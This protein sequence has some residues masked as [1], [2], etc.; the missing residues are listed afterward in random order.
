V[1]RGCGIERLG[2]GRLGIGRLGIGRVSGMIP[3]SRDLQAS[4]SISVRRR[5]REHDSPPL[6]SS[7]IS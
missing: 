3:I 7:K 2:I 6:R 4:A 1:N 5:W